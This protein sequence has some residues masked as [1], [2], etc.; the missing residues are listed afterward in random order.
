DIAYQGLYK[1]AYKDSWHNY[2]IAGTLKT[3]KGISR[4]NAVEHHSKFYVP[5]NSILCV[6]SS[7]SHEEVRK[8]VDCYFGKW[9][10]REIEKII[11][12]AQKIPTKK[13][14][15][16]KKG[17]SQAHIIY[18]FDIQHL[19]R[20]D[21]IVLTLL[22][23]KIGSGGNSILF[24]ELR[25]KRGLAY[26]V[27]T[28]IDFMK[29][30]KMLYIYAGVSSENVDETCTVIEEIVS[31]I[32]DNF[33]ISEKSLSLLKERFVIDTE[34]TLQSSSSIVDYLI[35]G[36]IEYNSPLEYKEVLRVM[37]GVTVEDL[38]TISK[39]VFNNPLTYVLLPKE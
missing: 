20:Q 24:K 29:N 5:N 21:S 37:E 9:E 26:S 31:E 34:V 19:T 17:I 10:S 30:L 22:S 11:E 18:A 38:Q 28:D 32:K 4:D 6:V 15:K 14:Q 3:V 25:D 12:H 1:E 7:Y 27:Y 2:H 23:E 33:N 16:Y 39:K 35:Q 8:M 13:I 36:E